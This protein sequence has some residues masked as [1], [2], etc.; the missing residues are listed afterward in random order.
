MSL[1]MP[2]DI[3]EGEAA[4]AVALQSNFNQIES[5]VNG[6]QTTQISD[7]ANAA[8]ATA[9]AITTAGTNANVH[10][11]AATAAHAATAISFT[12]YLTLTTANVQ[13]V[14]SELKDE[15]ETKD[16]AMDG[17]MDLVEAAEVETFL[18]TDVGGST[19]SS[20]VAS[21]TTDLGLSV[22]I[23]PVKTVGIITIDLTVDVTCIALSGAFLVELLLNG[24]VD[25]AQLIWKPGVVGARQTLT[26]HWSY[27]Y[28]GTG[29]VAFT[30]RASVGGGGT[31]QFSINGASHTKLSGLFV[32]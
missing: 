11:N 12:D 22:S 3:I 8:T 21:G 29:A 26:A 1:N 13:T 28:A 4:D 14:I 5:F 19:F 30:A 31:G 18:V 23:N 32:G 15:L 20:T 16:T 2:H 9:A 24:G 7:D 6:L 10:V 25:S 27:P 17:R